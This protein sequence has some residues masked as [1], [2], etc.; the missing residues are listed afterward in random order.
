MPTEG[1]TLDTAVLKSFTDTAL[2]I[3][4][5]IV[6]IAPPLMAAG[7]GIFGILSVINRVPGWFRRF[8]G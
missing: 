3:G 7:L 4:A 6:K 8:I 5:S 1:L 2:G